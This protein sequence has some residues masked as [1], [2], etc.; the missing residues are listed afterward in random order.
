M[1]PLSLLLDRAS[2][3]DG[4]R[5]LLSTTDHPCRATLLHELMNPPEQAQNGAGLACIASLLGEL[6]PTDTRLEHYER[7]SLPPMDPTCIGE[8]DKGEE[9]ISHRKFLITIR[10][11]TVLLYTDASKNTDG[12]TSSVW[13]CVKTN[14]QGTETLFEG[15]CTIGNYADIEDGEIHRIQEGLRRLVELGTSDTPVW[16]CVDNQHALRALVGGP[17]AGREFIRECLEDVKTLQQ[18]G[19]EVRGK[20][21]PS[22]QGIAGNQRADTLANEGHNDTDCT[23]SRATYSWLRARP[24]QNMIEKWETESKLP[25]R[26]KTSPFPPTANLPRRLARAIA[27]LRG[28]LTAL[29]TSPLKT[30]TTCAC[31]TGTA[32]AKHYV[33]DCT[34]PTIATVQ[35]KLLHEHEGQRTWDLITST[36]IRS[37]PLLQF[38]ATAGLL[39]V[40]HILT[41]DL[42]ARNVGY[43]L[44]DDI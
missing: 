16:I 20:W 15:H 26:P 30:P 40:Q 44:R 14:G 11:A 31:T 12:R 38:M 36:H 3:Q 34:V 7:H 39:R 4:I 21:T 35:T 33:M 18:R 29:D 6:I 41:N 13:H 24:H 27:S 28:C 22:H 23:G 43:E 9:A 19:C 1:P 8:R 32:R 42:D 37:K 25:G 10:H 17:I 5:V 2:Q